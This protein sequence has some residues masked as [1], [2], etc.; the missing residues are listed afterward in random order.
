MTTEMKELS[1]QIVTVTST[2]YLMQKETNITKHLWYLHKLMTHLSL[3]NIY[4]SVLYVHVVSQL[5]ELIV[6]PIAL[7]RGLGCC[8]SLFLDV[9]ILFV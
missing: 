8:C 9:A 7:L 4:L 3:E 2:A 5:I 1:N 6:K